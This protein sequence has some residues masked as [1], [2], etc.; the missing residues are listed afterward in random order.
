MT[1]DNRRLLE[2]YIGEVWEQGDPTAVA[3]FAHP[4]YRRHLSAVSPP[5]D[6][7]QQ[8]QRLVGLRAAF[9]DV[10]ITLEDAV[11][12]GDRVAFRCVLRGTHR[13]EFLGVAPTGR[14]VTVGLLDVVRIEDGLIAEQWGGP[15]LYDLVRQLG[16]SVRP[17]G[18]LPNPVE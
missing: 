3:R 4:S 1:T 2:A 9:P 18:E 11:A 10:S 15:D 5:L 16:A 12:E 17:P 7:E 13:G 6:L 14:Q 8:I